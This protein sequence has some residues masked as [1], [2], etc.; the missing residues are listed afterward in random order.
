M[1]PTQ[2]VIPEEGREKK[3]TYLKTAERFANR[4]RRKST[5]LGGWTGGK[6]VLRTTDRSQ[7]Y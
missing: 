7:K 5:F 1:V 4:R 3:K 2:E 6:A